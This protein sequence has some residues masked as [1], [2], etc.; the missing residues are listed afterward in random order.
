MLNDIATVD[1]ETEHEIVFDRFED[2]KETGS[3]IL[4]DPVLFTTIAAGII[5]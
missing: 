2:A 1:I 3:F 4:I 5:I